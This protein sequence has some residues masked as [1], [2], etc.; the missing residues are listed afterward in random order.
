MHHIYLQENI[1]SC[2]VYYLSSTM[3]VFSIIL[4]VLCS[5]PTPKLPEL[6]SWP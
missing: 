2:P 4:K 1:F 3:T 5:H 6:Q